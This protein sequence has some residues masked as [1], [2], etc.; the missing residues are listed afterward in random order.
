MAYHRLLLLGL[1]VITIVLPLVQSQ[2]TQATCSTR[3][4]SRIRACLQPMLEFA[5][6]LQNELGHLQFADKVRTL[7]KSFCKERSIEW[8]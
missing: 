3:D 5:N 8:R 6:D 4:E 1:T 7:L 2:Y